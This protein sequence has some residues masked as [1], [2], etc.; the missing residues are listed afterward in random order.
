MVD[1]ILLLFGFL[2]CQVEFFV[3]YNTLYYAQNFSLYLNTTLFVRLP[4]SSD[5]CRL[6][7]WPLQLY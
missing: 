7:H 1:W 3:V 5:H 4:I 6:V 2:E